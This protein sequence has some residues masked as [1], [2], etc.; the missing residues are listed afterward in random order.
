MNIHFKNFKLLALTVFVL[1]VTV[2][3]EEEEVHDPG[4]QIKTIENGNF[5]KILVNGENQSMYFFAGDVTGESNCSGGCADVWIAVTGDLDELQVGEGL[6]KTDFTVIADQYGENQIAYKGWPLYHFSENGDG[7]LEEPNQ[8]LG[9]GRNGLFHVA[10]PDYSVL[11][12]RQAIPENGENVT[13]LVNDKGVTL[14]LNTADELNQS[15]CSGGCANIWLPV[16]YPSE[17]VLP[18][19]LNAY[20]FESVNRN[21]DLGP[22]LSCKGSPLYF[23]SQ[24]EQ[25]QGSVLGQ[26]GGP[27]QTFFVVEDL[28]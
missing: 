15:N 9:D 27:N 10:K 7:V 8:V 2:A 26:A 12:G 24:D 6:Y 20:D 5:G 4:F 11:I 22:Q 19:S 17:L 28:E 3:C 16:E 21:D 14:Y 23:F 13:Y 25:K 1:L 18:S